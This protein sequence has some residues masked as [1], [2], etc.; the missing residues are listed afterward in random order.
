MP[1]SAPVDRLE[2]KPL[3]GVHRYPW[4]RDAGHEIDVALEERRC[5]GLRPSLEC[6]RS[7]R[8]NSA[9]MCSDMIRTLRCSVLRTIFRTSLA[10]SLMLRGGKSGNGNWTVMMPPK[11]EVS[12]GLGGE[13]S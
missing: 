13:T 9:A 10:R 1:A 7:Y 11:A 3:S 6:D 8:L 2:P 5:G 4:S 12:S